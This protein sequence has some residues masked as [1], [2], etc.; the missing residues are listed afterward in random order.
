MQHN[1]KLLDPE[2]KLKISKE[3][4]FTFYTVIYRKYI[5][6]YVYI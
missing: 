2:I 5:I 1:F 6:I 3:I 4:K